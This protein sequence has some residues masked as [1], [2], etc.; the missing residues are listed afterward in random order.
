MSFIRLLYGKSFS[1][2]GSS[3]KQLRQR[4]ISWLVSGLSVLQLAVPQLP[5]NG[6]WWNFTWGGGCTKIPRRYL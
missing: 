2:S 6:F 3:T 5:P 4:T 1:L